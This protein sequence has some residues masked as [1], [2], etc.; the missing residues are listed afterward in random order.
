[1]PKLYLLAGATASG[2]T[3]FSIDF[4]RQ[5]NCEI[6]SCDASCFYKGMDI[7]TAKP[8]PEEQ[9]QVEHWGI[10]II[11]PNAY[12]SVK[13]YVNYAQK[14]VEDIVARGHNVLVVGGSGFYLKSF[15]TPIAD[16][17]VIPKEIEQ[18]IS[19]LEESGGLDLL[20]EQLKIA[21]P[22]EDLTIDLK[23]PRKVKKAL[24]RCWATGKTLRELEAEFEQNPIPF[25]HLD[26]ET[27]LLQPP[28]EVLR[29]RI[30]QRVRK[31]LDNGLLDEVK[32]L[33][34]KKLLLPHTPAG[35]AI[36]YRETIQYLS[37]EISFEQLYEQIVQNTYA[38]VKK[39]MTW[40]RYQIHFQH[41]L[42]AL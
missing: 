1:M 20:V 24:A 22:S 14:C 2:K 12:F 5:H 21:N 41:Y 26:K 3:A 15:L 19:D 32:T 4:A 31:M 7:G 27:F 42:Y 25:P 28:L 16:D 36:G 30:R 34:D 37:G 39:Q 29:L 38:L 33:L 10:D 18:K 6:L 23:N 17:V 11:D 40:F 13:D 35:S 8:T 9:R